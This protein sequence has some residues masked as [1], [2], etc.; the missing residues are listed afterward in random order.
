MSKSAQNYYLNILLVKPILNIIWAELLC[1]GS[2]SVAWMTCG[3]NFKV[4]D[5][6]AERT[7]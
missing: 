5:K 7:W 1:Q 4:N 2:L 6:Q 3:D